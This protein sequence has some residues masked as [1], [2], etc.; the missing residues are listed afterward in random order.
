MKLFEL[1]KKARET[2]ISYYG[3]EPLKTKNKEYLA[4]ESK[5]EEYLDQALDSTDHDLID[6]LSQLLENLESMKFLAIDR[7]QLLDAMVM[8]TTWPAELEVISGAIE[9]LSNGVYSDINLHDDKIKSKFRTNLL[10][11]ACRSNGHY[12]LKI[13]S[14]DQY[15]YNTFT[16][17][18]NTYQANKLSFELYYGLSIP[19]GIKVDCKCGF[20][21][22]VN[23][24]HLTL[25]KV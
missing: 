9:D 7:E 22:C 4:Y 10:K 16:Y 18:K 19:V 24:F 11:K 17:K 14:L 15:G 23:P 5:I 13:G 8:Q 20:K 12:I 25:R 2:L 1:D 6:N 3:L 21:P